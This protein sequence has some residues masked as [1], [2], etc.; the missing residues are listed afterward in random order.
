MAANK[1]WHNVGT[2]KTG[3]TGNSYLALGNPKSK[4]KP[5]NVELVVKDLNG[6]VLATVVNPNLN[7]QDPRKR[8]GATEEQIASVPAFIRA[9]VSLP[10]DKE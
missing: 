6:K 7:V 2:I 3:K 10:P 9:E 5:V 4:Y 8:P 1:E